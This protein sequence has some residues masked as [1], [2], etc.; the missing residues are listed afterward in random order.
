MK[1]DPLDKA[2][3]IEDCRELYLK[4]GGE[5][6]EQIEREMRDL[7]YTDFHRRSM[8]RR[9]ERGR[10]RSGWIDMYGWNVLVRNAKSGEKFKQDLQDFFLSCLSW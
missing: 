1:C 7:G 4:Y 8:Y 6:H 5:R 3:K 10:C 9:Y 2:Q